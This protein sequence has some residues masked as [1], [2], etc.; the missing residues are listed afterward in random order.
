MWVNTK[1]KEVQPGKVSVTPSSVQRAMSYGGSGRTEVMAHPWRPVMARLRREH[2]MGWGRF[3][4][5]TC[6]CWTGSKDPS[7]QHFA[8][9]FA[10]PRTL[11]IT[12]SQL[13]MVKRN[14]SS[15]RKIFFILSY[16]TPRPAQPNTIHATEDNSQTHHTRKAVRLPVTGKRLNLI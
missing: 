9:I 6:M 8:D 13:F 16:S 4:I 3:K 15:Q 14:K 7:S 11:M 1:R 5:K 12:S 10:Q 2:W